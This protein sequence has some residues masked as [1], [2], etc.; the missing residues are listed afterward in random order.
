MKTKG[1]IK[2][3][4]CKT[5]LEPEKIHEWFGKFRGDTCI[6]GVCKGCVYDGWQNNVKEVK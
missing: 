6:G 3:V 1:I 2:C 5:E 4:K